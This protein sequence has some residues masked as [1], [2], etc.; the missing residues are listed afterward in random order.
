MRW[1][2]LLT[3]QI[4]VPVAGSVMGTELYFDS[5]TKKGSGMGWYY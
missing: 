3:V 2:W 4:D 1:G 5:D